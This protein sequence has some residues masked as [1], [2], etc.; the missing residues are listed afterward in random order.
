MKETAFFIKRVF[1]TASILSA[2]VLMGLSTSCRNGAGGIKVTVDTVNTR[3]IVE[4]VNA[5]GKIQPE[6]EVKIS[7]DVSG[8]IVQLFV[9]E[10]DS[11]KQGQ[12]LLEVN[13]DLYQSEFSRMQAMLDNSKANLA[14]SE[15]RLEQS[16][17]QLEQAKLDYDRN[18]GLYEK[19]VISEAEWLNIKTKYNV[20]ISD[21]KA[22]EKT[23]QAADYTVKST[24]AS[25]N[26]ARDN[27]KRTQIY[28]PMSGVVSMLNVEKGERI[29]GTAQMA[30]TEM[31]RIANLSEM[32]VNVEVNENDIVKVD[33][34]D[35]TIIEVDAYLGR[36]FKG[37]VTQ[38][39]N[40]AKT[41]TQAL[42]TD[43]VTNFEVKIRILR[44]SYTDLL[45]GKKGNYS[46]FRPGMSA[47][48]EIQTE[49]GTDVISV[50]IQA[51]TTRSDM[52]PSAGGSAEYVFV[53]ENNAVKMVPVK[54]SIQDNMYIQVTEGLQKGQVIVTGPYK[55]V[56]QVLKNGDKVKA[57]SGE[58]V[59]GQGKK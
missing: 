39:A 11:V 46:P 17:A 52:G 12:L 27:L 24:A 54:T 48:V 6:V 15:A 30:G 35:T 22:A 51:V 56:S 58:E 9:A 43:E 31:L 29:V 21:V 5:S 44:D 20:A 33:L 16:K 14:N 28:A 42:S 34:G 49:I 8:E 57:G 1:V 55:T 36:K 53:V 50:P 10:G 45:T 25:L 41:G 47:T 13:P 4:S 2:L 3:N 19:K 37:I 32:E 26:S 7:S 40:S 23:M 59:Y 18:K 38:I